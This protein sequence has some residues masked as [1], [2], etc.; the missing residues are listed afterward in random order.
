MDYGKLIKEKIGGELY[1][2]Q[3][4]LEKENVRVD[5]EGNLA[6]TKHPKGIG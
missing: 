5:G 3:F 4:G 1:Q 2:G 6:T